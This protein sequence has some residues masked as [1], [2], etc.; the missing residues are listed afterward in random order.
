MQAGRN[1]VEF[2]RGEHSSWRP[3]TR[4]GHTR[5]TPAVLTY[6]AGSAV[7][8]SDL[9]PDREPHLRPSPTANLVSSHPPSHTHRPLSQPVLPVAQNP[10]S[11]ISGRLPREPGMKGSDGQELRRPG[12]GTRRRIKASATRRLKAEAPCWSVETDQEA[13]L[14]ALSLR[15]HCPEANR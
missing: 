4:E 1:G 10:E 12:Q 3:S 9:W 5:G 6:S 15:R 11:N 8:T 13:S 14:D 2:T 7:P